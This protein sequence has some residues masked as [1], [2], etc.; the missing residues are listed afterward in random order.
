MAYDS[1]SG[2]APGQSLDLPMFNIEHVSLQF[3]VSSDFVAA[4]V[5]NNVLILALSTGRILR[6][7]LD[8]PADID[9]IDLPKKPS[10]IG[11]IKRLFLDPSASHLIITTTLA[12]NYYLHTQSRTPKALPR[13][14]GV[15][16]ESISWN[17]SPVSY[18]HLT[19]PTIY[20]V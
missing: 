6:I 16:I 4:E 1:S 5:A 3:N 14:K 18:T 10:E 9:D 8:Q 15:A 11:I 17:P 13:L 20:S 2:Y 12:E 7:D 19:L